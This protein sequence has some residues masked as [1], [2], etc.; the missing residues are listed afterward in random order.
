[1]KKLKMFLKV[2]VFLLVVVMMLVVCGGKSEEMSGLLVK[3][4]VF[5]E[6][7]DW[8]KIVIGVKNDMCL[9]GLKNLK[10]GEVE[11]FDVDIFK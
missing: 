3:K 5:I 10:M 8:G 9:F 6:I 7:K 4:D 1:M 11:G 2:V